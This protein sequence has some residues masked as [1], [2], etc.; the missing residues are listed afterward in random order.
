M[1]LAVI[2][3]KVAGDCY[4]FIEDRLYK[5]LDIKSDRWFASP[6]GVYYSVALDSEKESSYTGNCYKPP[7]G[8]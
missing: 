3:S 5:P 8:L 4:D 7:T 1:L 6:D 2:L